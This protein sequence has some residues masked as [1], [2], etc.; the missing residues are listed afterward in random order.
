VFEIREILRVSE[1]SGGSFDEFKPSLAPF[2]MAL[3]DMIFPFGMSW[4]CDNQ[5]RGCRLDGI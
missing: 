4:A 3:R 5:L 1:A 2:I